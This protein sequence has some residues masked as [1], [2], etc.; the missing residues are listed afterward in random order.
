MQ[1][2]KSLAAAALLLLAA[3]PATALVVAPRAHKNKDDVTTR[4]TFG[5]VVDDTTDDSPLAADCLRLAKDIEGPCAW[6]IPGDMG[7]AGHHRELARNG[8]CAVGVTPHSEA[9][10]TYVGNGDL[11]RAIRE[12]VGL[13]ESDGRIG[14]TGDMDCSGGP[15]FRDGVTWGIYHS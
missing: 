9:D 4:C 14:A 13:Y 1:L 6:A 5:D 2:S 3:P 7:A 8:T 10:T 11:I 12:A 15:T